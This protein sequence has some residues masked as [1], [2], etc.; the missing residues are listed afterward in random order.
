MTKAKPYAF[1]YTNVTLPFKLKVRYREGINKLP[2][3][4]EACVGVAPEA[5]NAPT[6]P[7]PES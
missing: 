5:R 6:M 7:P 2:K 1:N 3:E 4:H